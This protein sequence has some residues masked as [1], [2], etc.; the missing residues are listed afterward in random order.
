MAEENPLVLDGESSLVLS[1]PNLS[2]VDVSSNQCLSLVLLNEF[3]HL[4]W[5]RAITLVLGRH[6]KLGYINGNIEAPDV[7][8]PNYEAWLYKKQLIMSWLL[9]SMER[10][11]AKI[12]SFLECSHL[13]TSH[14]GSLSRKCMVIKIILLE[15]SN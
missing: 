10:K 9:N 2:K 1:P 6:S 5:S 3:N 14:F 4:P 8:S 15:C 11:I 13:G 12:F 7:S